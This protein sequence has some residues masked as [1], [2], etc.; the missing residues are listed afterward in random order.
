MRSWSAF[1]WAESIDG[2]NIAIV[3]TEVVQYA[4]PLFF[5]AMQA[6]RSEIYIIV[7]KSIKKVNNYQ[8]KC[9]NQTLKDFFVKF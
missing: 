8:N 4:Q 9:N 2:A 3:F 7:Y 5:V 1:F 6:K